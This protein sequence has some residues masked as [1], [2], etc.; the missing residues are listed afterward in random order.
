VGGRLPA[1]EGHG[2]ADIGPHGQERAHLYF[3]GGGGR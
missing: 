3:P 1:Q 2:G